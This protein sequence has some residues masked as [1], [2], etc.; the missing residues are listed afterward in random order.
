M[1]EDGVQGLMGRQCC[2]TSG[3]EEDDEMSH[4]EL[5]GI[6]GETYNEI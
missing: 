1:I 2:D 6:P 5:E 3:S 4:R